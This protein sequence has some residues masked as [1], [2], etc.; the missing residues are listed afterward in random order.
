MIVD[1]SPPSFFGLYA[2]PHQQ[3]AQLVSSCLSAAG[4]LSASTHHAAM[5]SAGANNRR[6]VLEDRAFCS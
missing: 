5:R 4:C 1:F 2:S 3:S 6:N